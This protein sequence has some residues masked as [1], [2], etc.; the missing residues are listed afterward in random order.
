MNSRLV[1]NSVRTLVPAPMDA[2]SFRPFGDY[3]QR[4]ATTDPVDCGRDLASSRPDARPCVY[5]TFREPAEGP[6]LRIAEME[7]HRFSSQTFIH[8][9]GGRWMVVVCPSDAAGDPDVTAARA[10]VAGPG[11]VVT[12]K[13]GTWHRSLTVLD[14]PSCHAVVMWRNGSSADEEFRPVDAFHVS[15]VF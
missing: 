4:P 2:A 5:L 9:N 12:Y 10:F 6:Y 11:D 8:M 15:L 7:R 13:P 3:V 14:A 1:S